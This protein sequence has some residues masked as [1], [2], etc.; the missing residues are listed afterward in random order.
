[1]FSSSL[2]DH[3]SPSNLYPPPSQNVDFATTWGQTECLLTCKGTD[4]LGVALNAPRAPYPTVYTLPL[5]SISMGKGTGVVTSVPSDAP[6]DFIA[7]RHIQ[8]K[9]DYYQKT[10]G[11]TPEMH[12]PFDVVDIINITVA[13]KDGEEAWSSDRCV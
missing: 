8:G 2:P 3:R 11:I 7:L 6:D 13:A 4:L 1:M 5:D 12:Q 10:Y 9:A